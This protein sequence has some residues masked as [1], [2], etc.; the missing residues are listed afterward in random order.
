MEGSEELQKLTMAAYVVDL[1]VFVYRARG[2]RC[3]AGEVP[4]NIPRVF[5]TNVGNLVVAY[6]RS[7][8]CERVLIQTCNALPLT[9]LGFEIYCERLCNLFF[10]AIKQWEMKHIYK[11]FALIIGQSA[12]LLARGVRKAHL[13][14]MKVIRDILCTKAERSAGLSG[15]NATTA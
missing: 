9:A 14:A 12:F 13:I 5:E 2:I 3:D 11:I 7:Y 10:C 15:S 6:S 1:V 4:A 8:N